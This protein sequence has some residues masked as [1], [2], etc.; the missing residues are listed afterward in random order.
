[1]TGCAMTYDV[2]KLGPDT[3][4]VSTAASPARG[5]AAGARSMA[6]NA[7]SD[8]CRKMDREVM[9]TNLNGHTTNLYGAG[10]TDVVF[11]CLAPGDPDLHRPDY[12][13]PP[14]V[15]IQDQRK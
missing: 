13:Q 1:M 3:Y 9:V 12:Q 6:I 5:G 2:A 4:T 15:I 10:S 11:R 14:S 7:A 8:Y